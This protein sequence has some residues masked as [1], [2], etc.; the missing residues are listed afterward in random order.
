MTIYLIMKNYDAVDY[1]DVPSSEP[2]GYLLS[3][4]QANEEAEKLNQKNQELLIKKKEASERMMKWELD[5]PNP[6]FF[7]SNG[8]RKSAKKMSEPVD[9]IVYKEY[10]LNRMKEMEEYG[11]LLYED[12]EKINYSVEKLEEFKGN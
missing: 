3:E 11:Y 10:T 12:F 1:E 2:I 9:K 7:N 8:T 6:L 5:N 4:N